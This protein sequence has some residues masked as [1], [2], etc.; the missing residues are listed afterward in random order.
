MAILNVSR[1]ILAGIAFTLLLLA[2]AQAG[3]IFTPT[4][5][6]ETGT[7]AICIANNVHT[8]PVTVTVKLISSINVDTSK[9]CTL[10]TE[11]DV[12]CAP[13]KVYD[14]QV[15]VRCQISISGLTNAQVRERVRGVL[16]YRFF[17]SG[18]DFIPLSVVEAD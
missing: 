16:F 8:A 14:P 9:T 17:S 2:P 12:G 1:S 18:N 10:A 4:I 11:D 3:T 13:S 15:R 7:Q 5:I 6:T